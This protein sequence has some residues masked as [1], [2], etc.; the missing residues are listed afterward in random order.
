MKMDAVSETIKLLCLF[1]STTETPY[2]LELSNSVTVACYVP[3]LLPI[4]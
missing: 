1:A 2:Q 4:L 3:V